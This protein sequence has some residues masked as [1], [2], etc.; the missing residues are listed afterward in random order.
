MALLGRAPW[1]RHAAGSTTPPPPPSLLP[2]PATSLP[3]PC[4]ALLPSAAFSL[5]LHPSPRPPSLH[6]QSHPVTHNRPYATR[7]PPPAEKH[8]S[9]QLFETFD[10]QD[11]N[12]ELKNIMDGLSVKVFRTY[13]ASITL[14]R[15]L[16]EWEDNTANPAGMSTDEKKA[17]YDKAN[18]EVGALGRG[19]G[20]GRGSPAHCGPT[21]IF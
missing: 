9:D 4:N 1:Q 3:P 13:N 6:T 15:L 20:A 14:D 8:P 11:L 2:P 5:S 16:T 19:F 18:K 10:A 7:A 17:D 21:G 12:K